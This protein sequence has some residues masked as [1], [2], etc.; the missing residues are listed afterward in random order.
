MKN[1]D[2]YTQ[3]AISL[4]TYIEEFVFDENETAF[5]SDCDRSTIHRVAIV[6]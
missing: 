4:P 1:Y 2:V 6:A 3:H 5:L